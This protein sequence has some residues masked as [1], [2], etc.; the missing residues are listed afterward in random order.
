M[1]LYTLTPKP[2][3]ERYTIQVGWNPHRT[4]VATVVD[5][6]WDPVTEPHRQPDSIHLGRVETILDTAEVLIAVAPYAE[7][8]ADLPARLRADQ[9][10]HPVR[11]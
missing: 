11:R 7:I 9:A 8:P 10:A 3:F 6:T 2:G 5:F 4:Y 1:S